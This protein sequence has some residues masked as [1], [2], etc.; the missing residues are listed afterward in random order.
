[1]SAFSAV[2]PQPTIERPAELPLEIRQLGETAKTS[3]VDL[4]KLASRSTNINVIY[5][6][7]VLDVRIA[8][9]VET[10]SVQ[11][12]P[13][14]V[15]ATGAVNVPLVGSVMVQGM[16]LTDAEYAIGRASVDRGKIFTNPNVSVL[17][18]EHQTMQVRVVGEVQ[19]PR[20]YELPAANSDILAAIVAAGGF[21]KLAGNNIEVRHPNSVVNH[22]GVTRASF[23]QS[24]EQ[25]LRMVPINLK[26]IENLDRETL[27]VEDGTVV[28]VMPK[29]G[30]T[31]SLLG[32]VRQ[33][34]NY[35]LPPGE[36]L[37]VLDALALAGRRSNSMANRIR[38]IR[39][40]PDQNDPVVIDVKYKTAKESGF[41]N[42]LIVPW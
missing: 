42:L 6:G 8:S 21:T 15:D 25:P 10:S 12:V 16:Q 26:D 34:G 9:G 14:R 11:H 35:E 32:L 17:L 29:E 40:V 2:D 41:E 31:V 18:R 22:D 36:S 33:P 7:D 30:Q 27:N 20:V 4:S 38:V 5:P 13:L 24:A 28:M 19:K 37:R 39:R 23:I 1:M 3:S